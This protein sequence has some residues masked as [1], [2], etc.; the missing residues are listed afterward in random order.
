MTKIPY[1]EHFQAA[2]ESSAFTAHTPLNTSHVELACMR[3]GEVSKTISSNVN[4]RSVSP[5]YCSQT[6]STYLYGGVIAPGPTTLV[7]EATNK[8][9]PE[10]S[11]NK[12]WYMGMPGTPNTRVCRAL[13]EWQRSGSQFPDETCASELHDA[14]IGV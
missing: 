5:N 10:D 1:R 8:G 13:R 6:S 14:Y 11:N 12:A 7:G 3:N 4:R 2:Q 9:L